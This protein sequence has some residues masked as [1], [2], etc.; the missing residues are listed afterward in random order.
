MI[1]HVSQS[2]MFSEMLVQVFLFYS[3]PHMPAVTAVWI[4]LCLSAM[5]DLVRWDEGHWEW[6]VG[7]NL[8]LHF[9]K[10]TLASVQ[11]ID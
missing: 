4:S 5:L 10:I 7:N 1:R 9:E 2:D 11:K 8:H 6:W 3:H